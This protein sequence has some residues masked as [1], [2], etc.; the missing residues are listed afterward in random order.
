M[1]AGLNQSNG[2]GI[3]K[4][5]YITKWNN[6]LSIWIYAGLL[7]DKQARITRRM[8]AKA[9][10]S[11]IHRASLLSSLALSNEIALNEAFDEVLDRNAG[12][13]WWVSQVQFVLHDLLLHSGFSLDTKPQRLSSFKSAGKEDQKN[14]FKTCSMTKF[15]MP[16]SASQWPNHLRQRRIYWLR[17]VAQKWSQRK[18]QRRSLT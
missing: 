2:D 14:W 5:R 11:L 13:G 4:T 18:F 12:S 15:N 9:K 16:L 10:R 17:G 1:K 7:S 8:A 6:L 3:R